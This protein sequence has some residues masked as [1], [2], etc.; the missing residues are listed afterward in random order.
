MKKEL[1]KLAF[2]VMVVTALASCKKENLSS[3]PVSN[4]SVNDTEFVAPNTSGQ[5]RQMPYDQII[6]ALEVEWGWGFDFDSIK[7]STT[8][9]G[10]TPPANLIVVPSLVFDHDYLTIII[11]GYAQLLGVYEVDFTSGFNSNSLN[12]DRNS[13]AFDI[14]YT[15]ILFSGYVY[16]NVPNYPD[17]IYANGTL[18]SY[19][20]YPLLNYYSTGYINLENTGFETP[21]ITITY[22]D[23][24]ALRLAGS[25]YTHYYL[26]N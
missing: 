25:F 23:R 18:H 8:P 6:D 13:Y 5:L 21:G 9:L 3:D 26:G 12:V 15:D 11:N 17:R 4:S 22:E 10:V 2:V 16:T 24:M 14:Y 1:L 19:Y 20:P 7:S